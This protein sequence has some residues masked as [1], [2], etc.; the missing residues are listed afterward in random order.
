MCTTLTSRRAEPLKG[1]TCRDGKVPLL[2]PMDP[3]HHSDS[4]DLYQEGMPGRWRGEKKEA[5]RIRKRHTQLHKAAPCHAPAV[6]KNDNLA[7]GER[8]VLQGRGGSGKVRSA[9]KRRSATASSRQA[10]SRNGRLAHLLRLGQKVEH[11]NSTIPVVLL[12][13]VVPVVVVE[14]IVREIPI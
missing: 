13:I 14:V 2:S 10:G 7:S 8:H 6:I 1:T 4:G 3:C 11:H 12:V 9:T 5:M